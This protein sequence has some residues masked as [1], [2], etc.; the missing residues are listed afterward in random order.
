MH[1]HKDIAVLYHGGCPDGFGAAY[2]AWK[3]FGD[4]AEYIPVKHQQPFPTHIAGKELY[5]V[6][7]CYD[8]AV[9][10]E[11]VAQSK[12]LTVLDHHEGVEDVV[13]SMPK[14]VYDHERSGAGIAWEFFNPGTPL[15]AFLAIVQK[16][17]LWK[18]LTS[19]ERAIISYC[20]AQ[21][22]HFDMW[23]EHIRRVEDPTE[24]AKIVEKGS[25]YREY[26]DLLVHQLKTGAELVEFEGHTVYL[27]PGEKMFISEL[28][29]KLYK[30]RPPFALIVRASATGLRVSL[31]GDGSVD[32]TKIAAKYGGNGHPQ[33]SA[34]SINW[35]DPIPW[36][37]IR[38]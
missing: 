27:V 10:D 25:A 32:L 11:L 26:F 4:S 35:G 34:F 37:V 2:S 15:P 18:E 31:R 12:S 6:D 16:A 5:L 22:F 28:G 17:D 38:S 21:P 8:K 19:D 1:E 3:K 24:R 36:K 29:N 30:E 9:M 13:K 23:S 7:F 14:F 20:Y 33:S